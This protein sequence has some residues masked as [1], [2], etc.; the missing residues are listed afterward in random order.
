MDKYTKDAEV[1]GDYVTNLTEKLKEAQEKDDELTTASLTTSGTT[2]TPAI[3]DEGS[4]K[5]QDRRSWMNLG[6]SKNITSLK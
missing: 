4:K 5:V 6:N 3:P 1:V 2:D